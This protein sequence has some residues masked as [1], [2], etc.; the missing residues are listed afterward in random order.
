MDTYDV[1]SEVECDYDVG[2]EENGRGWILRIG[3]HHHVRIA[4]SGR[5]TNRSQTGALLLSATHFAV[6]IVMKRLTNDWEN[7][8]KY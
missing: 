1:G 5:I 4:E 6:V 7:V 8:L 2:Y 3:I